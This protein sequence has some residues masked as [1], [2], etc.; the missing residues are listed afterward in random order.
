MGDIIQTGD[1]I[2][3]P[4]CG[5]YHYGSMY[6]LSMFKD[7]YFEEKKSESN[8]INKIIILSIKYDPDEIYISSDGYKGTC[9]LAVVVDS[10]NDYTTNPVKKYY[11]RNFGDLAMYYENQG[12]KFVNIYHENK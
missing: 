6:D 1:I 11:F 2:Q 9:W 7:C 3:L 12:F 5:G 10:R 4:S 8:I